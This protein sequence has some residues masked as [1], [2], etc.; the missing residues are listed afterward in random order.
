M[1]FRRLDDFISVKLFEGKVKAWG[2]ET[3]NDRV[4]PKETPIPQEYW[5]FNKIVLG[6]ETIDRHSEE[7]ILYEDIRFNHKEM[8]K[9]IELFFDRKEWPKSSKPLFPLKENPTPR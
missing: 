1:Q 8:A 6:E 9:Q 5:E 2:K 3:K 7:E 4:S